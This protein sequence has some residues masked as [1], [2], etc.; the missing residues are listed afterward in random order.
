M[1]LVT[2][3]QEDFNHYKEPSMVLGT[4]S[5]GG[6][7]CKEAN[8]DLSVCQNNELRGSENYDISDATLVRK[9]VNNSITNAIVFAGLEPFEQY[10]EM[11]K[12]ISE[13][14]KVT[15]DVIVIY[16]GYK[17][18]ELTEQV[19]EL[20]KFKNILIKFG[21]YLPNEKSHIDK[22][23][24]VPLASRNQYSKYI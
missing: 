14:R 4:I 1:R 23:L 15:D 19:E 2:I 8:I 24:G 16:T 3:S 6:K 17:E 20:S 11:V 12:L 10:E 7:C 18:D 9:Y 22:N 13:F 21:R 5:C